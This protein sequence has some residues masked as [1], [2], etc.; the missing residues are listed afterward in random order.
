MSESALQDAAVL[1]AIFEAMVDAII[2][3]DKSGTIMRANAAADKLFGHPSGTLVGQNITVLMPTRIAREHDDYM[4]H[5]IETG[6]NRIIGIGRDV[7]GKRSDGSFFPLHLTVGRTDAKGEPMFIAILHDLTQR[8]ATQQALSRSQRLDALGQMTG[9]I[10]HDFNNLLTIIIGNLELLET[11]VDDAAAKAM[12]SDA[13]E[14]AETGADLTDRLTLFARRG[15]LK[16]ESFDLNRGCEMALS[17]LKRTLGPDYRIETDL[18]ADLPPAMVDPAQ[19]QSAIVN[20]VLNARDAMPNG[21]RISVLTEIAQIDDSY[22]AQELNV[23]KG[24][25]VRVSVTDTG[26]GMSQAVQRHVFE[27]FFTTKPTGRGTGL[28]LAMVYGFMRQTGGHATL[29]SEPEQGSTFALYFPVDPTRDDADHL[30][31]NGPVQKP[32]GN[33]QM[34]LIVDDNPGILALSAE[35]IAALGYQTAQAVN[36]DS[37]YDMLASG[38]K[39]DLLFSDIAMPGTM[40]GLR[41][42]QRVRDE[43]PEVK[44]LL[45]SGY[46]TDGH[47][48]RENFEF[49]QKP[50]RQVTLLRRLQA[51][52]GS[53]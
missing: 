38:L 34:V 30:Q 6:E 3:A 48:L 40:D 46:A 28:G 22:I 13:L 37:A 17:L 49:L 47:D 24:D 50:Y 42:A 19:F 4:A 18:T 35:R 21:G 33:G 11:R 44:I 2:V 15:D 36:A 14:A 31:G 12:L 16:A 27:P 52:L 10:S 32:Q 5:H 1:G 26:V 43:Y 51:M 23:S 45:T 39:A 53:E 8:V 29:Y 9:G 41:L 7:E 20:L 25:Y